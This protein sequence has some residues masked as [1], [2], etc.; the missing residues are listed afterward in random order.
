MWKVISWWVLKKLMWKWN[1]L[2]IFVTA[3]WDSVRTVLSFLGVELWWV[4]NNSTDYEYCTFCLIQWSMSSD[5]W[6]YFKLLKAAVTG[7]ISLEFLMEGC[8][9]VLLIEWHAA[10]CLTSHVLNIRN[11]G[12]ITVH[13]SDW[14]SNICSGR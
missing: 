14:L 9:D 5:Y 6:K 11:H 3:L 10:G 2:F 1:E 12:G 7:Y 13:F 8:S 4:N